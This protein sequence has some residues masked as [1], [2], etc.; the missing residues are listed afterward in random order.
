MI[1]KELPFGAADLGEIRDSLSALSEKRR[2]HILEVEKMAVRIGEVYAPGQENELILRAAGLLHDV[3]KEYTAEEHVST[4]A[5]YGQT[6]AEIELE[7]PKTLHA[8]SAAAMIP[9]KFPKF[10]LPEIVGAV[11]YHTTGKPNMN[12]FEKIIYL[13]D[14]IDESRKFDECIRLREMFWNFDFS[15]ASEK[16][17]Q[18]HLT[19]VLIESFDITFEGLLE[20]KKPIHPLTNYARNYLVRELGVLRAEG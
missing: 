7:A 6:P 11:R 5:R 17:K 2:N 12:T 18:I 3:T 16:E 1:Y 19:E 14:Y 9:D 10:A 20:D 15:T 13:A 8:M 4:L